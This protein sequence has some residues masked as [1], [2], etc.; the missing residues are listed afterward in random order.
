MG[1][2]EKDLRDAFEG[3]EYTP[4][5]QVWTGVEAGLRPRKKGIFFMWQTYGIAATL[6]FLLTMGYLFRDEL[7]GAGADGPAKQELTQ[8][9]KDQPADGEG[10]EKSP[11]AKEGENTKSSDEPTSDPAMK[12]PAVDEAAPGLKDL[13]AN[14]AT[15]TNTVNSSGTAT[16]TIDAATDVLARSSELST[17]S[18]DA[19]ASVLAEGH[20]A[21]ETQTPDEEAILINA[22]FMG[23]L[24]LQELKES[25][26]AIKL[27]WDLM[28]MVEPMPEKEIVGSI[29]SVDVDA[30]HT[31]LNGTMGSSVFNPNS[32]IANAALA[33][34]ENSFMD[35]R[36]DQL[37][38]AAN[39]EE[40]QLGS[41]SVGFGVG[42]PL[43]KRWVLKTGLRYSQYRFASTSN[44]Y[45]NENGQEL[46]IY[47]R[48][49]FDNSNVT[50]A[51]AYEIT[52]TLHSLSI[53]AQF[54]WRFLNL[55]KF[56]SWLN[57]GVAADYFVSYTVKGDL[58]FLET[59]QVDF[60]QS[61]FINRFNI[62]A[63]TGMEFTY[64]LNSKLA[65]SGEVYFRQF[66]PFN[67]AESAYNAAP[68]VFG[69]GLGVNYYLRKKE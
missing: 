34:V 31:S 5:E 2:F 32:S 39:T 59:R 17:I 66:I 1:D 53:P 40:R 28:N 11:Q 58:N 67:S 60:A 29:P 9:D 57:M 15:D 68:S 41:I 45:S 13:Q 35:Q 54:G 69:F 27:R 20:E 21:D 50:F 7:F 12:D 4:S 43:G 55:G 47:T 3:V 38:A 10:D 23:P 36:F 19:Q 16:S 22:S 48:V 26:A 33:T 14:N 65:L 42:L 44:A 37:Q 30:R 46:P 6:V 63:L 18:P 64:E 24:T 61:N 56:S 8:N 52:N 51:G 25:I 62:N 49:A